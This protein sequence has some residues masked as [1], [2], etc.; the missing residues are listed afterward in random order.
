MHTLSFSLLG[1]H[2]QASKNNNTI[3]DKNEDKS[4]EDETSYQGEKYPR[5]KHIDAH[6]DA[7]IQKS[8]DILQIYLKY[9]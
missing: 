6:I 8:H 1:E 4:E 7:E 2:K 9:V 3:Y 5:K